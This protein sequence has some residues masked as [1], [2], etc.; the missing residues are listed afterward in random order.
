MYYRCDV[1]FCLDSILDMFDDDESYGICLISGEELHVYIANVSTI[2]TTNNINLQLINNETIERETR[3]RRGGSSSGRYGRINDK[4][5]N[6]NKTTFCEII[7]N[8]YFYENHTKCKIKKLILAGPTEM[9]KEISETPLFQQ[10]LQKYLFKIVNTNG[11]H[12]TT[13]RDVLLQVI[14]E[15]KYSNIKFVDNEIENLINNQYDSLTIG[16]IE[17]EN[18]IKNNNIIKLYLSKSE[19]DRN[20]SELLDN[21]KENLKIKIIISDSPVLKT[22]GNWLGVKKYISKDI[23]DYEN[24]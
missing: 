22:Y 20:L 10:H 17:T 24:Y 12:E 9:K 7:I 23:D 15:I 16:K 19:I 14:D 13:A 18:F 21:Y 4:A 11:I 5:K 6:F 8:S 1:R 3:T 2:S